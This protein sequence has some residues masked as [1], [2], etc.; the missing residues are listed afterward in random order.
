M[1]KAEKN[2]FFANDFEVKQLYMVKFCMPLLMSFCDTACFL[3]CDATWLVQCYRV[4]VGQCGILLRLVDFILL[5]RRSLAS[6]SLP[7]IL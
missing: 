6:P 5:L 4:I 3:M 7:T 1:A 2:P